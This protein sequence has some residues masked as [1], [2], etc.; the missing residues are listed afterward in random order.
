MRGGYG[1][2]TDSRCSRTNAPGTGADCEKRIKEIGKTSDGRT[3]GGESCPALHPSYAGTAA[4]KP[5]IID[6]LKGVMPTEREGIPCHV[7]CC[8]LKRCICCI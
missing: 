4:E 1:K 6:I 5:A 8:I 7:K 3:V 2:N